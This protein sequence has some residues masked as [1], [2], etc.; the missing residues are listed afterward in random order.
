MGIGEY[1]NETAEETCRFLIEKSPNPAYNQIDVDKLMETGVAE[2]KYDYPHTPFKDMKFDTPS[3]KIEIYDESLTEL[4]EACPIH[5]EPFES[6][7]SKKAEKYPLTFMNCRTIY[8]AH[9]QHVDL[10]WIREIMPEPR[11]EMN[12]K[13]AKAR[14]IVDGDLVEVYNDRGSYRVKVLVT[15]ELVPGCLN[16]RQGWWPKHFESGHYAELLHMELN[17]TQE[18]LYETNY[19]PYDNLVEVKKV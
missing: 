12:S 10:P 7:R 8:T 2:A 19:A 5:Y 6:N 3:G 1:W 14:G 15:D 9:S 11:L 18:L 17:D 4:G 16:Q 13:D